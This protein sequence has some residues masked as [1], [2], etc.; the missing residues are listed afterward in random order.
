LKYQSHQRRLNSFVDDQPGEW[1]IPIPRSGEEKA[2]ACQNRTIQSPNWLVKFFCYLF[3]G[4]GT[5]KNKQKSLR[6]D[7]KYN[8]NIKET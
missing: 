1:K 5:H 8:L 6:K 4:Y 3:T 2:T 7:E